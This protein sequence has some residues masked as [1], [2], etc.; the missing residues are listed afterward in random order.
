MK[1]LG[2]TIEEWIAAGTDIRELACAM[3]YGKT[4]E[5]GDGTL[6]Q[7]KVFAAA[8]LARSMMAQKCALI[9]AQNGMVTGTK[10]HVRV[11]FEA[12]IWLR[13]LKLDGMEFVKAILDDSK[14][15]G[16]SFAT[17]LLPTSDFLNRADRETLQALADQPKTPRIELGEKLDARGN[18]EDYLVFRM[19]SDDAVHAS[20]SSLRKHFPQNDAGINTEFFVEPPHEEI[21]LGLSLYYLS[22]GL[23]HVME[24]YPEIVGDPTALPLVQKGRE[25][26]K[27]L[28][29]SSGYNCD[30]G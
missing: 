19:L 8:L 23:L 17:H 5:L 11:C 30:Q 7:P 22:A 27:Q 1:D 20:F 28:E 16:R 2:V 29:A 21:A 6:W 15:Q 25:I 9:L 12:A 26:F 14:A 3:F 4:I 13:I 24:L 18:R 10:L